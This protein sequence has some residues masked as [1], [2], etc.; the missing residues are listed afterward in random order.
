MHANKVHSLI[1]AIQ[2][3]RP[4]NSTSV[5]SQPE[6]NN[7]KETSSYCDARPGHNISYIGE[8][9]GVRVFLDNTVAA[10][11]MPA[12]KFLAANASALKLFATILLDCADTFA[13]NRHTLHIFYDSAGSTIAFN[14][15]KSLFFN[16][17]YFENLHL[18]LVQQ[19]NRP[20]AIAYWCVV[21]AHE[22]AHNLVSEH[23]A[24]HS[25]YTESLVIQYFGKIASKIAGQQPAPT[26][27]PD[28]LQPGQKSNVSLLD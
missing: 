18:P 3:S 4:H 11:G 22:L 17:R 25:Y 8:T 20:D 15:N 14:Q 5:A 6:V 10:N 27:P 21:M 1:N 7:V 28:P 24:Q 16:Y 2:A 26:L 13:L 19:G 23:S 9:S 12:T